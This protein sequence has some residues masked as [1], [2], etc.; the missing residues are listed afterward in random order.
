M[1]NTTQDQFSFMS[2]EELKYLID[3]E[4]KKEKPNYEL[5][6]KLTKAVSVNEGTSPST[7]SKSSDGKRKVVITKR[8]SS[9]NIIETSNKEKRPSLFKRI[10]TKLPRQEMRKFVLVT[11]LGAFYFGIWYFRILDRAK[12]VL[13]GSDKGFYEQ[14]IFVRLVF[15]NFG[16]MTVGTYL[17]YYVLN[18]NFSSSKNADS[19]I[20]MRVLYL[21]LVATILD[22]VYLVLDLSPNTKF[23]NMYLVIFITILSGTI[24]TYAYTL[25]F[26]HKDQD[27]YF[28]QNHLGFYARLADFQ[29]LVYIFAGLATMILGISAAL[30]ALYDISPWTFLFGFLL[31]F[32]IV[33]A[34]AL[35][36]LS[37]FNFD[38]KVHE[39]FS[40]F[41]KLLFPSI[42]IPISILVVPVA[43]VF[44]LIQASFL[45]TKIFEIDAFENP[46]V[47]LS[48]LYIFLT[49]STLIA[50]F[51]L[52]NL[53]PYPLSNGFKRV[54]KFTLGF[55]LFYSLI[56]LVFATIGLIIRINS[57]GLTNN[58]IFAV[59]MMF[60]EF[61]FITYTLFKLFDL[62]TRV[63]SEN[64][65]DHNE[66]YKLLILLPVI[67]G[68]VTWC[69]FGII[70]YDKTQ[71]LNKLGSSTDIKDFTLE[72]RYNSTSNYILQK[73]D[74]DLANFNYKNDDRDIDVLNEYL[75]DSS[76]FAQIF[77][78]VN[79]GK[80]EHADK[81]KLD[82]SV[83]DLFVKYKD[84]K[85]VYSYYPDSY[86]YPGYPSKTNTTSKDILSCRDDFYE[87]ATSGKFSKSDVNDAVNTWSFMSFTR[88]DNSYSYE[89]EA[90]WRA[91]FDVQD[92]RY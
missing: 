77:V 71:V 66:V 68:F 20:S 15:G 48:Q 25:F 26:R 30:V 40:L 72:N 7:E 33:C 86:D 43:V 45:F 39:E 27:N 58:R 2:N 60:L 6:S 8:D 82:Q 29:F 52:L 85:S 11:V 78:V 28:I 19:K 65:S 1:S 56:G 41:A 83:K 80:L 5:I 57:Y 67:V 64:I 53:R 81:Y 87:L 10:F 51:I 49:V 84:S 36:S 23:L 75:E 69:I 91:C 24:K 21:L 59:F 9:S 73:V 50:Y 42:L 62:K 22:T 37:Y 76:K 34:G 90:F 88:D 13:S 4:L 12:D 32:C 17:V 61:V 3:T 18:R 47:V 74:S 14:N 46:T 16:L 44:F 63:L 89:K 92:Y 55:H 79:K 54:M 35:F 70:D 38:K 31:P